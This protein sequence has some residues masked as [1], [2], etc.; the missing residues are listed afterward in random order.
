MNRAKD[1]NSISTRYKYTENIHNHD[2]KHQKEETTTHHNYAY[3]F[4]SY[5][6]LSRV[7]SE[8]SFPIMRAWLH[9]IKTMNLADADVVVD[10][11]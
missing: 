3:G 8:R 9:S 4:K 11:Y 7:C 2:I 1:D 10:M 5:E 6:L